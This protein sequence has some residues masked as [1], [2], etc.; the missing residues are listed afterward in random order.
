MKT[1]AKTMVLVIL[2]GSMMA[3]GDSDNKF[4]PDSS[5]SQI[6]APYHGYWLAPAYGTLLEVKDN[7]ALLYRY[8][9]DYCVLQDEFDELTTTTLQRSVKLQANNTQLSWFAGYGTKS[10]SAPNLI[11]NKESIAPASCD[12]EVLT[13]SSSMTNAEL[14]GLYSQIM[15]EYYVDFTRK[16]VDWVTLTYEQS[17]GITSQQSTFLEAIYETMLPLADGH[18][19]WQSSQGEFIQILDKPTHIMRL[20]EEFANDK[21]LTYPLVES[22]LTDVIVNSINSYVEGQLG[23][24]QTILASYA[25][26]DIHASDDGLVMWT[27]VDNVGYLKINAMTGFST[28]SEESDDLTQ[29]TSALENINAILD[30]ALTELAESQGLI[31]DIREN[32]GGNDYISL[33]IASRFAETEYTAYK[34][35][36]REGE[37]YTTARSVIVKPS[38]YVNYQNKPIVLLVSTNTASAAEVFSLSMSQLDNVKLVGEVT[39]GIFSDILSWNLPGGHTLGLSNELY[40]TPE[41]EWLEGI[42]VGV[43]IP[44]EYFSKTD[45]ALFKD[46]GMEQALLLLE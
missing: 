35:Y 46:S 36:A 42:G 6:D 40:V 30:E 12:S 16:N 13:T 15:S 2:S 39:Q 21:G 27:T 28:A 33:A 31:I 38:E 11:F 10:F 41:D 24:E 25:S 14:F 18:N 7:S 22:E 9:S 45:R 4:R 43:D 8:T 29:V 3:C 32:G 17:L 19:S 23:L 5:M 34:K 37:G 1:L 20:I 44:V 26:D